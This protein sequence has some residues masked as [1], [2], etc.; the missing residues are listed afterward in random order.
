MLPKLGDDIEGGA[1]IAH[2]LADT[3]VAERPEKGTNG[4]DK[5]SGT[6][7]NY[8]MGQISI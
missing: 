6:G 7:H 5:F 8:F 4:F 3:D 2:H 1:G